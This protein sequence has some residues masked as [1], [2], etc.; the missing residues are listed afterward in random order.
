V[1]PGRR[2]LLVSC[3]GF[4]AAGL[5]I[6]LAGTAIVS[7]LE[8]GSMGPVVGIVLGAAAGVTGLLF[9]GAWRTRVSGRPITTPQLRVT[10][11]V[12]LAI[13]EVGMLLGLVWGFVSASVGGLWVGGALFLS[14]LAVIVSGV[15]AADVQ[16]P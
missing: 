15:S 11:F 4:G 7:S 14:S 1:R 5:L 8:G 6:I 10:M 13:A 2:L 12:A 3:A 9:A 16:D